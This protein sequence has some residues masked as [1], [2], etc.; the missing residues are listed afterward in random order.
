MCINPAHLPKPVSYTPRLPHLQTRKLT[1]RLSW[2]HHLSATKGRG[3]GLSHHIQN[4]YL[5]ASRCFLPGICLLGVIF[6]PMVVVVG[7]CYFFLLRTQLTYSSC[8]TFAEVP[9]SSFWS[10]LFLLCGDTAIPASP[11]HCDLTQ[12]VTQVT[13][14]QYTRASSDF[15]LPLPDTTLVLVN[16][17]NTWVPGELRASIPAINF[18]KTL[19]RA[20]R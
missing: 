1:H 9:L 8:L 4:R 10:T 19:H 17:R 15:Q 18:L 14:P 2:L 16:A 20:R 3:E 5:P 6:F 13:V 11:S 12:C 7:R